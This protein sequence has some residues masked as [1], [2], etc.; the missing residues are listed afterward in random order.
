MVLFLPQQQRDDSGSLG[1]VLGQGIASYFGRKLRMSEEEA[2]EKRK[3]DQRQ[4][5]LRQIEGFDEPQSLGQ[6]GEKPSFRD[7][8]MAAKPQIKEALGFEPTDEQLEEVIRS[9]A[10]EEARAPKRTR[11]PF[12]KAKQYAAIGEHDLAKAALEE[13]KFGIEQERELRKESREE[14]QERR[15]EFRE[16]REFGYKRAGKILEGA[17]EMR[18]TLPIREGSLNAMEDAIKEGN[19]AFFSLN[20]L[21]E[22]TGVELFRTAQGGQFKAAGKNFLVANVSKF[23]AR[24]NMYIEQQIADM[25][26]KIGRSREA[27]MG[28]L[29]LMKFEVDIDKHRLETID[30]LQDLY[31][32]AGKPIPSGFGKE[33]DKFMKPY[34]E[35]RQKDLMMSLKDIQKQGVKPAGFIRMRDPETGDVWDIPQKQLKQMSGLGWTRQ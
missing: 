7:Q 34:V 2:A 20:N 11:D 6:V 10:P 16:E 12:M 27:N 9:H 4:Q 35:Q 8:L 1:R 30:K 17:D 29:E 19:Q 5:L 13:A 21:A 3:L 24:P 28:A 33:V 32:N 18:S 23:G 26:P 22:K 25:L 31:E 14:K 15:K